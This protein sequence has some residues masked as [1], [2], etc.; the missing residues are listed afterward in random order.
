MFR[1]ATWLP[2][3]TLGLAP[4]LTDCSPTTERAATLSDGPPATSRTADAT[5]TA[6]S[7][8]TPKEHAD[9]TPTGR[10][11][12]AGRAPRVLPP[13]MPQRPQV[14][15]ACAK[16]DETYFSTCDKFDASPSWPKAPAPYEHCAATLRRGVFMADPPAGSAHFDAEVT[17]VMCANLGCGYSYCAPVRVAPASAAH[18]RPNCGKN[19]ESPVCFPAPPAGVSQPGPAPFPDC[20]NAVELGDGVQRLDVETTA[21]WRKTPASA[22]DCC[23]MRCLS[24]PG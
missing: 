22:H 17:R 23:Y 21:T 8:V 7:D 4:A 5:P 13:P 12:D 24:L 19:W 6:H 18:P 3:L 10:A 11:D 2:L 14:V 1:S 9:A 20:P 15:V 16:Q